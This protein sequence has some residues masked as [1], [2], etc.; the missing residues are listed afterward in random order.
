MFWSHKK[1]MEEIWDQQATSIFLKT[2]EKYTWGEFD[3]ENL[4]LFA[5]NETD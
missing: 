4:N 1:E 5:Y 3:P 2:Q